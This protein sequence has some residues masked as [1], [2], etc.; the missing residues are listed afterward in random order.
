M[1]YGIQQI[2]STI[3]VASSWPQFTSGLAYHKGPLKYVQFGYL[4]LR[5]IARVC[6]TTTTSFGMRDLL[7]V[8]TYAQTSRLETGYQIKMAK[9]SRIKVLFMSN[10]YLFR[11][12]SLFLFQVMTVAAVT[13]YSIYLCGYSALN[14]VIYTFRDQ[15]NWDWGLAEFIQT[16]ACHARQV[17]IWATEENCPDDIFFALK[18]IPGKEIIYGC[19]GIAAFLSGIF[20]Q[21][22]TVLLI[23]SSCLTLL[24]ASHK[25]TK[26]TDIQNVPGQVA[27]GIGHGNQQTPRPITTRYEFLEKFSG[28]ISSFVG[29]IFLL[30][31]GVM[32]IYIPHILDEI[33]NQYR[34]SVVAVAIPPIVIMMISCVGACVSALEVSKN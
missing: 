14:L 8:H 23:M 30:T 20:A 11:R 9:V 32:G 16:F 34:L 5:V 7:Q 22:H 2:F 12:L 29:L 21:V 27:V 4:V 15:M 28:K 10:L 26:N 24:S 13:G 17:F 19:F 25:L 18:M 31:L 6:Y 3:E 1:L 33:F